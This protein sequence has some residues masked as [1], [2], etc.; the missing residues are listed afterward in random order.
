MSLRNQKKDLFNTIG[1]YTSLARERELP[2]GNDTFTSLTEKRDPVVFLIEMLKAVIGIEGLKIAVGELFTGVIDTIKEPTKNSLKNQYID[3]NVGDEIPDCFKNNGDG[4]EI[5]LKDFDFF[6]KLKT[7]PLSDVGGLLYGVGVDDFDSKIYEA[8]TAE[9]TDV[10]YNNLVINYDSVLDTIKFRATTN[11]DT[12]GK[13]FS[14]FIDDMTLIKNDVFIG[15]ILNLIFGTSISMENKSIEKIFEEKKVENVLNK[16]IDESFK[17]VFDENNLNFTNEELIELYNESKNLKEGVIEYN[18]GCEI[19]FRTLNMSDAMD[20]VDVMVNSPNPEE[21]SNAMFN[22]VTEKA[23]ED[24]DIIEKNKN[25][26]VDGFFQKIIFLFRFELIKQLILT[27]QMV[28]LILLSNT[29]RNECSY[30]PKSP[31][32]LIKKNKTLIRCIIKDLSE[33]FNMFIYNIIVGYLYTL[34]KPII[35]KIVKEKINQYVGILKS[36]ILR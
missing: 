10:T 30:E 12:I 17:N 28:V 5:P 32:D 11:D 1:A 34:L 33:Q 16:F 25:T 2:E 35:K 23:V 24:D 29:I 7:D 19:I 22:A 31:S 8:I 18:M 13:W 27:P 26:V 21:I 3:F 9:G 20:L 36:L 4:I 6:S 14:D 15:D